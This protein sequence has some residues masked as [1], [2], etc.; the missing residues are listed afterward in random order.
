MVVTPIRQYVAV[1]LPYNYGDFN[2]VSFW[3]ILKS[4]TGVTGQLTIF[5]LIN[6]VIYYFIVRLLLIY[7]LQNHSK[8]LTLK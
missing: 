6:E 2:M 3:I 5:E 1:N 8:Q 4:A 7:S